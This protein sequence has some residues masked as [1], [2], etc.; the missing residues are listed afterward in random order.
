MAIP[1][2]HQNQPQRQ[3]P[4]TDHGDGLEVYRLLV[5]PP[6][7]WRRAVAVAALAAMLMVMAWHSKGPLARTRAGISGAQ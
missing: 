2:R 7:G 5:A 1:G 3:P 6:T 4:C